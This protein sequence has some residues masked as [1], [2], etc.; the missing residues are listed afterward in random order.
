VVS[1][2]SLSPRVL[3]RLGHLLES[4]GFLSMPPLIVHKTPETVDVPYLSITYAGKTVMALATD[5]AANATFY[6]LYRR[7]MKAS[8]LKFC[9]ARSPMPC[10]LLHH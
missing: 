7:L 6:R 1:T 4:N 8:H 3:I 5:S 10:E 2:V 9:V